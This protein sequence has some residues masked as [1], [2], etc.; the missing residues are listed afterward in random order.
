[1]SDQQ[2][3]LKIQ[4]LEA[5]LDSPDDIAPEMLDTVFQTLVRMRERMADIKRSH[6]EREARLVEATRLQDE[7]EAQ[8]TAYKLQHAQMMQ[9]AE[10]ANNKTLEQAQPLTLEQK[11]AMMSVVKHSSLSPALTMF[12]ARNGVV[13]GGVTT[14]GYQQ[15]PEKQEE[16]DSASVND[17]EPMLYL[18]LCLNVPRATTDSNDMVVEGSANTDPLLICEQRIPLAYLKI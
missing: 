7:R 18:R 4:D 13:G 15:I 10:Q 11:L 14:V 17:I 2:S 12:E 5:M 6:D 8:L 1:M 3:Q 16:H 9:S